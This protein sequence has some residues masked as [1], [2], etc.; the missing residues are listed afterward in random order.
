MSMK[1]IFPLDCQSIKVP[2]MVINA[3]IYCLG[4]DILQVI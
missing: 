3:F 4:H 2:A 1:I